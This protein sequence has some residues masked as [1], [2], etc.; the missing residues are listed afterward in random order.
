[1]N[2]QMNQKI[3]EAVIHAFSDLVHVEEVQNVIYDESCIMV[4]IEVIERIQ[5]IIQP[6]YEELSNFVMFD[7][8]SKFY[9]EHW[10][11]DMSDRL[12]DY[13]YELYGAELDVYAKTLKIVVGNE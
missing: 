11:E 13:Y 3:V 10:N 4:P 6:T 1:M 7:G 8:S 9:D 5:E 2:N 12:F